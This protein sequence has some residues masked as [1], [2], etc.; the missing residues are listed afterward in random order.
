MKSLQI[1]PSAE[2]FFYLNLQYY[3]AGSSQD[4]TFQKG[5][6]CKMHELFSEVPLGTEL[7]DPRNTGG[8][9]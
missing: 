7:R 4:Q 1:N 8:F 3:T 6:L 2:L 5:L 9:G